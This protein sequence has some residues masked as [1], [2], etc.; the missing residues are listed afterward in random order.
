MGERSDCTTT[1][2]YR[3]DGKRCGL[4]PVT[5]LAGRGPLCAEHL[6]DVVDER[7]DRAKL[8]DAKH[9]YDDLLR[10]RAARTRKQR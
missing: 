8:A 10:E 3:T 6:L 9:R 2:D 5:Q 1:C 4:A 7:A